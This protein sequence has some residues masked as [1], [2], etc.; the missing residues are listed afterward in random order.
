[1]EDDPVRLAP[2][3][4]E[5]PDA[6]RRWVT[7]GEVILCSGF[8]TQF[9]IGGLLQAFGVAATTPSGALSERFIFA[10]S[11]L[12]AALLIGLVTFFL[13]RRG[14][15]LRAVVIGN[16]RLT[17]E[18]AVGVLSLPMVVTIV[19]AVSLAIRVMAP[20]LHNIPVN[21]LEAL[22]GTPANM[23]AF[24]VV[25]I[26]AG[27]LREEVQRA[28]LLHRFRQDLGGVYRG[29]VITSV[30]FGLGHTLQGWDAAFITAAL[31]ATWG[32]MYISR[33]SAVA[34]IVSHSLFNSGEILRAFLMR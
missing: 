20:R 32:L 23:V 24:L 22:I 12:D 26:V 25:V 16:Q 2:D 13:W 1:M 4:I 5:R 10:L 27:G 7:I 33:G 18:T 17:R 28:F 8:P 31:G 15:H 14:E 29:L 30:A 9:A 34:G 6:S 19:V 21:P 3:A 11:L